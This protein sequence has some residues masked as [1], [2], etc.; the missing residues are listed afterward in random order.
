MLCLCTCLLYLTLLQYSTESTTMYDHRTFTHDD[1]DDDG[2]V[3]GV[4]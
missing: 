1:D 2:G 3:V 4:Y